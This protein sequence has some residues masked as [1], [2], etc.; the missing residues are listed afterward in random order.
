MKYELL[1]QDIEP[2]QFSD[3]LNYFFLFLLFFLI[4]V[5]VVVVIYFAKW[6]TLGPKVKK[7]W[8]K[9]L[10]KNS[11]N[12]HEHG[13]RVKGGAV[14]IQADYEE[15]LRKKIEESN[16]PQEKL[17]HQTKLDSHVKQ[18][19]KAHKEVREAEAAK[20]A[21]IE[22]K[23]EKARIQREAKEELK[24]QRQQLKNQKDKE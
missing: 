13:V 14:E 1:Y 6:L 20:L 17:S 12:E 9:L 22:E 11:N 4:I 7:R 21:K 23:E 15:E 3:G 8:A 5:S 18:K 24:K 10:G 16:S 19:E 2:Q